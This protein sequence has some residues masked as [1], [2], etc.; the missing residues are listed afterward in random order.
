MSELTQE[1]AASPG[2]GFGE[3]VDKEW[4]SLCEVGD[5]TSPSEYPDMLLIT[6]KELSW[7]MAEAFILAKTS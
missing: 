7:A 4:R 1:A 2:N 5:R 3:L 6:H